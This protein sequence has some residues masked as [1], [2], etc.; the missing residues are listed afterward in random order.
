MVDVRDA[1]RCGRSGWRR[2]GTALDPEIVTQLAEH[3]ATA[4]SRL[5]DLATASA[6]CSALM[7]EGRSNRRLRGGSSLTEKTVETHISNIFSKLGLLQAPDD[8]RRVL[9]VRAWMET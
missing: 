9:A 2:G 3:R 6:K 8:H 7:A 4:R 1:D 5:D